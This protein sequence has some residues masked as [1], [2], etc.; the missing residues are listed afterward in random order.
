[1]RIYTFGERLKKRFPFKVRKIGVDAGFTCPNRD[2]AKAAGGCVYCDNRSF[3]VNADSPDPVEEQI[4]RGIRGDRYIAYFQAYT[5]TYAPVAR[6]K[7]IYSIALK[8]PEVVGISIGTRPDC[9]SNAVIDYLSELGS[10]LPLW[11]EIGLE[12]SHDRSL[13]W[14]NRAHTY[15]DF[16]D[17]ARRTAGRPFER[18]VHLI[19]GIPGESRG[20]MMETTDRVAELGFDSIKVHHLYIAKGTPLEA[21]NPPTYTFEEWLP[22]AA[23]VVERLPET[24]SVQRLCGELSNRWLVAPRWGK[25]STDVFRAV[26]AELERRGTRQGSRTRVCRS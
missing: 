7:E 5:N 4:R 16:E 20:D 22:L 23:D 1:M 10:R 11:L 8:F 25:S 17:A 18:V 13:A 19:Y 6:L 15:A 2:G 9:L 21:M 3:S 24:M 26:D 12:S 14:M